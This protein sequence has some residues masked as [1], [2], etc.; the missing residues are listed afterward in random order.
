MAT[1]KKAAK[2]APAR[3]PI[4]EILSKT[5]LVAQVAET[6]AVEPKTVK[7]VLAALEATMA[8][9][10]SRKGAGAFVMPGL[11]QLAS[12]LRSGEAGADVRRQAGLDQGQDSRDEEA[13]G[14]RCRLRRRV[15]GPARG[16][17]TVASRA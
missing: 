14:R 2:A 6:A 10:L 16:H 13:E 9:S 8:S 7:A 11:F 5:G 4:K 12:Y 17:P 1:A 3:K 15:A